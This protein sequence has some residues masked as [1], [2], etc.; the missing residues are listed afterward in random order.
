MKV[1]KKYLK[2]LLLIFRKQYMDGLNGIEFGLQISR[3][4]LTHLI[5]EKKGAHW[6]TLWEEGV[7]VG[8]GPKRRGQGGGETHKYAGRRA[9]VADKCD[10]LGLRPV[11]RWQ[12]SLLGWY[13]PAITCTT[14]P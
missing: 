10:L 13:Y 5:H 7:D 2:Y 12:V 14:G 11:E 8:L 9:G 6:R 4:L 1:P 3:H